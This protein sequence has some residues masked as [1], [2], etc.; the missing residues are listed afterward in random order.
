MSSILHV[1][2]IVEPLIQLI[3]SYKLQ[4][5]L[6]PLIWKTLDSCHHPFFL[7]LLGTFV[8]LFVAYTNNSTQTKVNPLKFA[9]NNKEG[10]LKNKTPFD[11]HFVNKGQW[12]D[13]S[14]ESRIP[15]MKKPHMGHLLGSWFWDETQIY[16]IVYCRKTNFLSWNLIHQVV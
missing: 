5:C 9:T 12:Y 7:P 15:K 14:W 8:P 10:S 3:R 11:S 6:F 13:A 2:K 1:S 4:H 16:L